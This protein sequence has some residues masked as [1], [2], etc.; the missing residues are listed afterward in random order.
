MDRRVLGVD[1]RHDLQPRRDQLRCP[2]GVQVQPDIGDRQDG[3]E[4]ATV[5]Q[6]EGEHAVPGHVDG[7]VQARHE[8]RHVGDRDRLGPAV[9]H[10][11]VRSDQ[12]RG[13]VEV[14]RGDRL[15]NHHHAG[16]HQ[17]GADADRAVTAHR[18]AAGHLDE[19]H[20]DV[21]VRAGRRL[22]DRAGHGAVPAG[23][24]HQQRAQVVTVTLEVGLALEHRRARQRADPTGDH[25][26]RHPLGVGVDGV[27]H[28]VRAHLRRPRARARAVPRPAARRRPA[29]AT[30]VGGSGPWA[31]RPATG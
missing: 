15:G 25:T 26:G 12:A 10:L 18:E 8:G 11:D 3:V 22:Q 13:S 19:Q 14:E 6:V 17:H 16:L 5:R 27:E 7:Q 9:G 29:T 4:V 1:R 2:A 20:A 31:G 30:G 23:L 21:G 28:P 24:V